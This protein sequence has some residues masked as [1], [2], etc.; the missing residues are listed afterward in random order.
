MGLIASAR[1]LPFELLGA[2]LSTFFSL[3][4][5]MFIAFVDIIGGSMIAAA[6]LLGLL[7]F[8]VLTGAKLVKN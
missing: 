1:A 6:V 3:V 7:A 4:S 8:G 5:G 2:L